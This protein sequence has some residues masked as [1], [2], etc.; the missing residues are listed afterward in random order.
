MN[1]TPEEL[2]EM[3][4]VVPE[5]LVE[6][7][8]GSVQSTIPQLRKKYPVRRR[9]APARLPTEGPTTERP[10]EGLPHGL[11]EGVGEVERL[12]TRR[13]T[14]RRAVEGL[15]TKMPAQGLATRRPPRRR[16]VEQLVEEAPVAP[17]EPNVTEAERPLEEPHVERDAPIRTRGAIGKRL[18]QYGYGLYTD[19]RTG[20]VIFNPGRSSEVLISQG[21][22][23][24]SMAAP[25]KKTTSIAPKKKTTSAAPT[26]KTTSAAPKKKM[27]SI[28]PTRK[29]NN[30]APAPSE[31]VHPERI[32]APSESVHEETVEEEVVRPVRK[33]ARI[34][35]RGPSKGA[36][37]KGHV[38]ID[39][40]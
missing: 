21:P 33:S 34:M 32:A 1:R 7:A 22:T 5:G 6:T 4:P 23:Q 24:E 8:Q 26:K 10:I 12:D 2:A 15:A 11:G 19:D 38:H 36:R 31:S 35:N 9:Q 13:T 20:T 30:S 17:E 14:R 29:T 37:T 3:V 27:T 25:K 40:D 16:L 39:I 28:A 18:R